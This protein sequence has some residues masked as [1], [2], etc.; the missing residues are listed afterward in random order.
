MLRHGPRGTN[1]D[2]HLIGGHAEFSPHGTGQR[3]TDTLSHLMRP[4]ANED[5]PIV[6]HFQTGDGRRDEA[7]AGGG[8]RR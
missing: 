2:C 5:A 8:C 6:G 4:D 1:L 7:V 3:R